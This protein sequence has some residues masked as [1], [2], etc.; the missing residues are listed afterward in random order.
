MSPAPTIANLYVA[1]YKLTHILPLLDK[2]L[3][4]YKR[5]I[6]DGFAIWLH[7]DNPMTNTNNWSDFKTIVNGSGLKWK[8]K[9]PCKKLVF[10]DMTIQ[11]KARN[12]VTILYAK[13]LALYQYI[14]TNSCHPPGILTRL[15]YDLR[16]C[17]PMVL[18]PW[19]HSLLKS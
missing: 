2:Y 13:P 12:I 1:I 3:P 16:A 6:E 17:E 4:F 10:M 5:F 19:S 9:N 18:S 7:D 15:V 11:I 14:L 8:F